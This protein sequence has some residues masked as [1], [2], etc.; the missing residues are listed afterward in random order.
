M[1]PVPQRFCQ[2][3][4][5]ALETG[6][7]R[8]PTRRSFLGWTLATLGQVAEEEEVGFPGEIEARVGLEE[9]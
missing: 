8:P 1:V 9:E 3:S 4:L 5:A 6:R 2:I 7:A